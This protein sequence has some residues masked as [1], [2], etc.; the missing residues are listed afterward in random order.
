[1][2]PGQTA[3]WFAQAALPNSSAL[4]CAELLTF[5]GEVD[6]QLLG[7][8]LCHCLD[9]LPAL[10][11]SYELDAQATPRAVPDPQARPAAE[12]LSFG[13]LEADTD[14]VTWAATT[15]AAAKAMTDGTRIAGEQLHGHH[16][17]TTASG[18]VV[19]LARFHHII[20]DGFAINSLIRWVG[21]TYQALLAGEDPAGVACP[22]RPADPADTRP[23]SAA[24]EDFW[25][26]PARAITAN[27]PTL[28]RT[29]RPATTGR[30]IA[31]TALMSAPTRRALRA[32]ATACS[33]SELDVL[34][35]LSAHYTS[36][37]TGAETVS[38]GL[39][40]MNRPL[41][42]RTVALEPAVNVLPLT[43]TPL[44]ATARDQNAAQSYATAAAAIAA[45]RAHDTMRGEELRRLLGVS[46]P[47]H[48]F[49]GPSINLRPFS[50]VFSFGPAS[51]AL[52]TI[53]VGLV[54]DVELIFQSEM[55]GGMLIQGLAHGTDADEATLAAHI[56][57]LAHLVSA[58]AHA[59]A[60][61]PLAALEVATPEE[62]ATVLDTFNAT[63]HATAHPTVQQAVQACRATGD[64][65]GLWWS[66][67]WL[68]RAEL[69]QQVDA[70]AA[71]LA[72]LGARP[73][74]LVAVELPRSPALSLTIAACALVGCAWL[75][76]DPELPAARTDYM[77]SIAHPVLRVGA[78]PEAD[79][80]L[81]PQVIDPA[82]P[83][84]TDSPAHPA[85]EWEQA[86]PTDP[87]YVLF[88]S[89]ST[90]KPKGVEV[91]QCGIANRL[92]WMAAYY[93]IGSGDTIMQK[94]HS[95]FDV[96]VWE[97]LLPF[98]HGCA[99]AVA[100]P[101][102]HRDPATLCTELADARATIC[103]FVPSA[104]K[105]FLAWADATSAPQDTLLPD[106]RAVI[107]SGEAL[108]ASVAHRGVEKLHCALHNLY[109]PTEASVDVTA[110]TITGTED[111]V[112]IGAPVWNTRCYVRD[113]AG[114]ILPV[115]ATGRLWLAGVQV[116]TGYIGR[117]ELT[118]AAFQED[119]FAEGR[120]YDSGDLARWRPDGTLD[121]LGRADSQV[122]LRGQRLE[123]AEIE[124]VLHSHRDVA[125]VAVGVVGL[126]SDASDSTTESLVAWV[127]PTPDAATPL[128]TSTLLDHAR[129]H[130]PAYM[131]P[132]AVVELDALPTTT[133]G[134]LDTRALPLPELDTGADGPAPATPTEEH[135]AAAM[136]RVLGR[137]GHG[138]LSRDAHFFELGG[139]SLSAVELTVALDGAI[140]VADIFAAPTVA[141]L[142]ARLEAG[143]ST[144]AAASAATSPEGAP[145]AGPS[146][147]DP[148]L[149]LREHRDGVPLYCLYPAG[150][151]SWSYT[152]L[153][154]LLT[155][156]R[157]GVILAQSP[158]LLPHTAPADTLSA[159]AA[160]VVADIRA[161]GLTQVD[162]VGW[163]VGG[164]LAQEV[165]AQ[166]EAAA[167]GS[168]HTPQVRRLCLLDAYPAELWQGRP[169]PTH[170]ELLQG[171]LTMAGR[172]WAEEGDE[173]DESHVIAA[174]R[175]SGGAFGALPE[176][177]LG[178]I[179][180]MIAHNAHI[181]RNHTTHP[182]SGTADFF[183]A[184][185]NPEHM[186]HT[187]WQDY[188]GGLRVHRLDVTHPG[189]VAPDSLA[190]VATVLNAPA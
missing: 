66:G 86:S 103:H 73:G 30:P 93:G 13:H 58:A 56:T 171:V 155:D 69:W 169:A 49:T 136:G 80:H 150:G 117:P 22:L 34:A 187:I 148:F 85:P 188:L 11:A 178:A 60:D 168:T 96:S 5:T 143:A 71:R 43:L 134:K 76:I 42:A 99:Q 146:G 164:V 59:S 23:I 181:M 35:A 167:A 41:G 21:Q 142:A 101:D 107:C 176:S 154:P 72:E 109:G 19:W 153:L 45:L 137:C 166:L 78:T 158:G 40:L 20:A 9:A 132:T 116:A 118:A 174:L 95:S 1:M 105:A 17:M 29:D 175:A 32:S 75:P 119:P 190:A 135:V 87:A 100:S 124:D 94:T 25:T 163:S 189:L 91:P 173:L 18:Q 57:R 27:P 180:T 79:V 149:V 111:T 53:S 61:A 90:G 65:G 36:A 185:R 184:E 177:V 104:L 70:V 84:L 179:T 144:N 147:F 83:L 123:P 4:Q 24:D 50:P 88:T 6:P 151:L 28:L 106:L 162:L 33:V 108:P 129:A 68:D 10:S 102:A 15:V 128:D 182:W 16:I 133:S 26:D 127:V 44:D 165:A 14:P 112:P 12:H 47:S 48:Q 98:T 121:Y 52:R 130:L 67:Q 145:G 138:S 114:R 55:D 97:F 186:D 113:T 38:L 31:A 39:P 156:P 170:H 74:T 81:D 161:R 125:Q 157:R 2:T 110:Y 139:T 54:H 37:M 152:G 120:M 160:L 141:A 89:G 46:D 63:A 115:G 183:R 8:A 82:R 126:G 159:A 122:K 51:A 77:R 62:K 140:S 3:L 172:D 131:V 92:E 7:R 64:G